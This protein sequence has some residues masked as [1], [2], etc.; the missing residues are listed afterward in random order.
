M[1]ADVAEAGGAEQSVGDGV[2]HD[3]GVAVAG[4]AA[5]MRDLDAAEHDRPFAGEGVDIE[6][7]AGAR[8]QSTGEPLLGAVEVG[9]GGEL[10]ERGIAF[11]GGDVH[12]G[13][14][15]G[16]SSR[17]SAAAPDQLA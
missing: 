6:A 13:A 16:R 1:L 9:G 8:D 3:V 4:E 12:A 7:H 10:V 2:K 17:R 11:D 5:L 15:E 14:R